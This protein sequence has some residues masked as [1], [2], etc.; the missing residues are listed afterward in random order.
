MGGIRRHALQ[1]VYDH[2]FDP[3]ILDGARRARA[4]LIAQTVEAMLDKRRRHLPTVAGSTWSRAATCLFCA[5]SAQASTIRARSAKA[6]AVLP[7]A[8]NDLSS[9]RSFSLNSKAANCRL[10]IDPLGQKPGESRIP[11]GN[12]DTANFSFG[13]LVS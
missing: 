7:R 3:G 10:A 1:R 12:S 11:C 5:P 6:C 9:A 8:A 2:P 4:R 13:T